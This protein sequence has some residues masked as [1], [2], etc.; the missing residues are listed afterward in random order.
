MARAYSLDLRERVVAAVASG[1]FL[2]LSSQDVYGQRRQCCEVVAA[3]ARH[4]QPSGAE[5]GWAQAL[6]CGARVSRHLGARNQMQ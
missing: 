5:N 1:E 6:P 2:P 3:P 4:R